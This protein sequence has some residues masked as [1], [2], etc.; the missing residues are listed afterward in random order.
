MPVGFNVLQ[1]DIEPFTGFN[2]RVVNGH[3]LFFGDEVQ[4]VA[5]MLAFAEAIP[6]VFFGI[7]PE[8]RGV[9]AAVNRARPAQAGADAFEGV[10]NTVVLQDVFHGDSGTNF[11]KIYERF[12]R[13]R[14]TPFNVLFQ[15]NK[16]GESGFWSHPSTK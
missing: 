8:L 13:H 16:T 6:D 3:I 12:F 7:N 1:R 4:D 14:M 10:E 2:G 5:A 15:G 11:P 9:A